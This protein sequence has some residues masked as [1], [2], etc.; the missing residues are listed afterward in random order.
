MGAMQIAN[1]VSN[2]YGLMTSGKT[3]MHSVWLTSKLPRQS[4]APSVAGD[5]RRRQTTPVIGAGQGAH[6]LTLAAAVALA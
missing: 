4:N 1:C 2:R 3:L 5:H 6:T